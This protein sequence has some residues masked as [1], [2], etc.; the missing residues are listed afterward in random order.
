[1]NSPDFSAADRLA[2][3]LPP[4]PDGTAR[5]VAG[6]IYDGFGEPGVRVREAARRLGCSCSTVRNLIR[7]GRLDVTPAGFLRKRRHFRVA[8]GSLQRFALRFGRTQRT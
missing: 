4:M 7:A 1:M 6:L 8:L 5:V 2:K 3:P